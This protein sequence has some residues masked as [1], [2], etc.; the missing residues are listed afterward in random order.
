MHKYLLAIIA[1]V[2]LIG[3]GLWPRATP[4][5]AAQSQ[6][7]AAVFLPDGKVKLPTGFRKWVFV[8]SPLTPNGLNSGMAGFLNFITSTSRRRTST[9]ISRPETSLREQ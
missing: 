4:P 5:V 9:R 1:G 3:A 6:D 7:S 8:G 2:G